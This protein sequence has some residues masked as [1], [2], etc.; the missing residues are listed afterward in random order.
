[1]DKKTEN[2]ILYKEKQSKLKGRMVSFADDPVSGKPVTT[3]HENNIEGYV[4]DMAARKEH[5]DIIINSI[6]SDPMERYAMKND[7]R[8]LKM[9]WKRE[10]EQNKTELDVD[11]SYETE[12]QRDNKIRETAE[13]KSDLSVY[14]EANFG[15]T[16]MVLDEKEMESEQNTTKSQREGNKHR[17]QQSRGTQDFESIFSS[18]EGKETKWADA[19]KNE[20]DNKEKSNRDKSPSF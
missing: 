18:K 3:E 19:V 7:V 11:S 6:R 9:E 17:R 5:I 20:S 16:V 8:D 15:M 14:Q 12:N 4:D 1:M 2:G 13:Q 10:A